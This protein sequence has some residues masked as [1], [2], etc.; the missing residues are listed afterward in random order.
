MARRALALTLVLLAS[1]A[2]ADSVRSRQRDAAERISPSWE[3]RLERR[4]REWRLDR[5]REELRRDRDWRGHGRTRE[6]CDN[7]E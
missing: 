7:E 2:H 3:V 4:D 6:D 5:R 1:T